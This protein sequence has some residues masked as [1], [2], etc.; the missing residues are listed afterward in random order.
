M[1]KHLDFLV[2]TYTEKDPRVFVKDGGIYWISLDTESYKIDTRLVYSAIINPSFLRYD[3]D[4]NILLSVSERA[5]IDG[6]IHSFRV[7]LEKKTLDHL[8]CQSTGGSGS[9]HIELSKNR[10]YLVVSNYTGGNI[11]IYRLDCGNIS[12]CVFERHYNG[13]SF[14]KIRQECS[15]PHSTVITSDNMF[16]F[17]ADLGTDKIWR[18]RITELESNDSL[19]NSDNNRNY[20]S[21]KPGSG[22]RHLIKHPYLNYI[23]LINELTA[24]INVFFYN[25]IGD[26]EEKQTISSLPESYKG[27]KAASDMHVH[28]GGKFLYVSNRIFD[29]ISVFKIDVTSGRLS[30]VDIFESGGKTPRG[31]NI[32]FE[33]R[34]L[35]VANQ[36]TNNLSVIKLN[37]KSG[38]MQKVVATLNINTPVWIEP[39][40]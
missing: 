25:K 7:D 1:T 24:E 31:F 39:L 17:V 36:D 13:K 34:F 22:P 5:E 8:S 16:L 14:D 9:C 40:L 10:K 15:H 19:C 27:E 29:T 18:H 23:Y 37:K 30:F 38:S 26:L 2:G 35:I 3:S 32:D 11:R 6:E 12:K 28:P 33:G 20:Y 4:N 21:M